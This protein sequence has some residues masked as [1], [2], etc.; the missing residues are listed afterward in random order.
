MVCHW[1]GIHFYGQVLGFQIF[2]QVVRRLGERFGPKILWMKLSEIARYWAAK[3]LTE[4]GL[5][6]LVLDRGRLVRHGEYPTATKALWELPYGG[7]P[8]QQDLDRQ[9]IAARTGYVLTQAAKHW[10]VDD[11]EHPY[12]EE[13]PFSWVRGY[14]VGGRSL[15]WGRRIVS[16]SWFRSVTI[17]S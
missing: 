10:F 4:R 5:K 3:E 8:T 13:K 16:S 2:Q 11:T 6:T 14:H 1:T 9:P 7:R 15:R 12:T 17:S